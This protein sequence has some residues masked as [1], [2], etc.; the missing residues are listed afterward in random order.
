MDIHY[1]R[2]DSYVDSSVPKLKDL[3]FESNCKDYYIDVNRHKNQFF[4]SALDTAILIIGKIQIN[5]LII[6]LNPYYNNENKFR[7]YQY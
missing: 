7:D 4:H 2:T 6:P 1:K 3:A 5:L